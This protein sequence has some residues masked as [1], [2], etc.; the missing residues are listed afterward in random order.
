MYLDQYNLLIETARL[1]NWLVAKKP[2]L[3]VYTEVHHIVPQCMGGTNELTN[4]IRLTGQEHFNAHYLLWKAYPS[5]PSLA[6]AA[7]RVSHIG[8]IEIDA[9]TYN[10]LRQDH[11]KA[12]SAKLTGFVH[13]AET[14][15]KFK[16]AKS[17]KNNPSYG[18]AVSDSTRQLHSTNSAGSNNGMFGKKHTREVCDNLSK[19]HS[20]KTLSEDHKSK[21][22]ASHVSGL[23]H[24]I[25][26]KNK[27]KVAWENRESLTC[28]HCGIVSKNS[29]NMNRWHFNNCRKKT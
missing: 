12:I 25:I 6:L 23:H 11:A 20:G 16:L 27:M 29:G 4:L 17:G 22:K 2:L 13:S 14:I 8:G 18:R 24:T 7:H 21:L 15:R 3:P 28:P 9:D 19:L 1:R 10:A 26:T 5:V